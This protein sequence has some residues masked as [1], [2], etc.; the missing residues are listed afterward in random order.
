[1]TRE[2]DKSDGH[3]NKVKDF[4]DADALRYRTD[5]YRSD[6]CEGL[7]Y[8]TR[9][10]IVL[11][12]ASTDPGRVLDV[13][14]GP[15]ILTRDLVRKGHEVYSADLSMEMVRTAREWAS[16]ESSAPA[17][18]FVVSDA[19]RICFSENRMDMVLSI[20]LMCY[21]KDHKSVLSEIYRVLKPGGFAVIQI[22]DIQWPTLYHMFVP[23]YHY[24][25]AMI[26]VTNYD[27]LT[28]DFNFS[29]TKKFL[30]ELAESRFQVLKTEHYDFR[31]PFIDVLLPR[32]SVALG[33]LMFRNR[34]LR[35]C[36]LFSHGLL[37]KV[38][39]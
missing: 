29:S 35:L 10:E 34:Q 12:M 4:H 19:S 28:F 20:G 18:Y 15:G 9:R 17:T 6:T 5:R 8:V 36:R 3:L 21:V 24:V 30:Q 26:G 23:L 14:C 11:S 25:K 32:L 1:M 13:G 37:I 39:K 16:G 27:K 33:K 7:A 31:I 2:A 38:R 22:N